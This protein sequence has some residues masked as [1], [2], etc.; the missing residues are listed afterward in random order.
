MT[1]NPHL[2]TDYKRNFHIDTDPSKLIRFRTAPFWD[3]TQRIVLIPYRRFGVTD[4][5]HRQ[6]STSLRL[7]AP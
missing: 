3:I 6:G 4:L 1:P 5:S 7:L 2:R